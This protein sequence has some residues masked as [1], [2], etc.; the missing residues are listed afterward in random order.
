[1]HSASIL[2]PL[3]ASPAW[4]R[5]EGDLVTALCTTVS[6][7]ASSVE[8]LLAPVTLDSRALEGASLGQP[9]SRAAGATTCRESADP[10]SDTVPT[11]HGFCDDISTLQWHARATGAARPATGFGCSCVE[12]SVLP[13]Q[14]TVNAHLPV[15]FGIDHADPREPEAATA[16]QGRNDL[17]A[18]K[19]G[20]KG[21]QVAG[22]TPS[23]KMHLKR[24]RVPLS[25]GLLQCQCKRTIT[26]TMVL[27]ILHIPADMHR[28][29]CLSEIYPVRHAGRRNNVCTVCLVTPNIRATVDM[30]RTT[31]GRQHH[32]RM[33]AG[34]RAF[35]KSVGVEVGDTLVFERTENENELGVGVLKAARSC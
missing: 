13:G 19:S 27:R 9:G 29:L 28:Q 12:P 7:D 5:I 6:M 1:M 20:R 23:E 35:C 4:P 8:D 34:W 30:V 18:T 26:N 10:L 11:A 21:A 3:G 24:E 33:S 2:V 31:S 16:D 22:R 32:R 15:Q 14:C 25:Q 17:S